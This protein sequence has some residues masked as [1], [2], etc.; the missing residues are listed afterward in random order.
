MFY[1]IEFPFVS[2][3]DFAVLKFYLFIYLFMFTFIFRL[4]LFFV[5]KIAGPFL[6][7]SLC[8]MELECKP[9]IFFS[10]E[11]KTRINRFKP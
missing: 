8:H 6:M 4:S 11:D 9:A 7:C 3:D 2:E 1:F 10:V 5:Q